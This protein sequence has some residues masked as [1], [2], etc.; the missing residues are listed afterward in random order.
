MSTKVET[1]ELNRAIRPSLLGHGRHHPGGGGGEALAPLALLVL[2]Q[3]L[4]RAPIRWRQAVP[5]RRPFSVT[6]GCGGNYI[7]I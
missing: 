3:Q 5:K 2:L 1:A 6:V 7:I 4:R